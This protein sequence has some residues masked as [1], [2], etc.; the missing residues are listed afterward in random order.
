M[1]ASNKDEYMAHAERFLTP[2][3]TDRPMLFE[4]FTDSEDESK[5][6]EIV[7][8]LETSPEG[9]AKDA[10]RKILGQSGVQALKKIL[11]K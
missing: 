2:E 1:S 9:M 8:H 4:V 6:L 3:L 7:N 11:K 5:A 10:A